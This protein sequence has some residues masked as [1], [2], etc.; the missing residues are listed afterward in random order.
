MTRRNTEAAMSKAAYARHRGVSREYIHKLDKQ[1]RLPKTPDG[2][3]VDV[4]SA[5][6]ALDAI[7]NPAF[8]DKAANG[9]GEATLPT[10]DAAQGAAQTYGEARAERERLKARREALELQ[11]LQGLLVDREAVRNDVAAASTALRDQLLHLPGKLAPG[12]AGETDRNRVQALLN[13]ELRHILDE[14]VRALQPH[15]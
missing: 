4:A 2:K 14:F 3:R 7:A 9:R 11:R 6:V 10:G 13:R 8:A 5:D 1:G 12:L 15:Q